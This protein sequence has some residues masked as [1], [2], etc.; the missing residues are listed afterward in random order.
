MFSFV[1]V[2]IGF[3]VKLSMTSVPSSFSCQRPMVKSC[4]GRHQSSA[5]RTV[6]NK[7]QIWLQSLSSSYLRAL[8]RIIFIRTGISLIFLSVV[9]TVTLRAYIRQVFGRQRRIRNKFHDVPKVTEC[10][11][12]LIENTTVRVVFHKIH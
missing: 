4:V 8:A 9:I 5:V 1:Y 3:P 11:V 10:L 12:V 7:C 2:G 6:L